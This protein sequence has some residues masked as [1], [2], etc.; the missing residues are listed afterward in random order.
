MKLRIVVKNGDIRDPESGVYD[1]E[2]GEKLDHVVSID[3]NHI[4]PDTDFVLAKIITLCDLDVEC[5][6]EEAK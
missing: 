3:I 2:T 1:A 6:A 4:G 5:E